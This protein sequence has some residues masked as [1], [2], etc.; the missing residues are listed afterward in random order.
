MRRRWAILMLGPILVGV[1]GC[2]G[3]FGIDDADRLACAA[4]MTPVLP[5][6]SNEFAGLSGEQLEDE[7]RESSLRGRAAARVLGERYERGE[8]VAADVRKAVSW[9]RAAGLVV[10]QAHYVYSPGF[11]RVPGTVLAI[12]SAGP[13]TPGDAIALRHL[14]ELPRA[15]ELTVALRPALSQAS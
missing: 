3:A 15:D 5:I 4:P 13:V 14:G 10:P 2:A 7:A 12:G 8:G 9:Y 1:G 6:S 11:G